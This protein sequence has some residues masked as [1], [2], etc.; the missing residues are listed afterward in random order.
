MSFGALEDFPDFPNSFFQIISN[1]LSVGKF[2]FISGATL[3][4]FNNFSLGWPKYV[5]KVLAP[6]RHVAVD[7]DVQP[8]F[9]KVAQSAKCFGSRVEKPGEIDEALKSALKSN[10]EGIPAVLNCIV[11]PMDYNKFFKE[12]HLLWGATPES[13]SA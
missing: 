6:G 10:K 3:I 9:E 7:Y 4:L 8:D 5:W 2:F 1:N 12:Y 11:K 13:I